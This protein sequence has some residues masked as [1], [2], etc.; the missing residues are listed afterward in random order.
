MKRFAW[1]AAIAV[2]AIVIWA[3]QLPAADPPPPAAK[4]AAP[5]SA[6]PAN[7]WPQ[8]RGPN[9]NG[10]SSETITWPAAGPKQLWKAA[11]G[12]GYSSVSVSQG[13]AYTMG[14][15]DG[16]EIVWCLDATTGTVIW[17]YDVPGPLTKGPLTNKPKKPGGFQNPYRGPNSTPTVDG[18]HV[19]TVSRDGLLSALNAVKGTL[20]WSVDYMR[21]FGAKKLRWGHAGSPLVDGDLLF[22]NVGVEGASVVAFDKTTGKV[23]W[24][25]GYDGIGFASPLSVKLGG[26]PV[27]LMFSATGLFAYNRADG[28]L[29][30]N[31][32]WAAHSDG[33]AADPII[34]G[35]KVFI[36]SAY[37]VG[38]CLLKVTDS[39]ATEVYR[40]K[41]FQSHFP[42]PVLIG[43]M[44]YG[45]TGHINSKSKLVCYDPNTGDIKWEKRKGG[46]G[47][48]AAGNTLLIQSYKGNLI[49]IEATAETYKEIGSVAALPGGVCWTPP[50]LA[51]GLVYCRNAEGDVV[52]LD[53]G[54]GGAGE[55]DV[56]QPAPDAPPKTKQSDQGGKIPPEMAQAMQQALQM[57][58]GKGRTKVLFPAALEWL[59]KDPT[60]ALAWVNE[61]PLP[62]ASFG[63]VSLYV[64]GRC[65]EHHGKITVDWLLQCK[66]Y[67]QLHYAMHFWATV[68]PSAALA[69]CLQ[70]P[71][72]VRHLVFC[73]LGDGWTYKDPAAA[74]AAFQELK[75]PTDRRSMA[76]GICKAWTWAHSEDASAATAW[77]LGLKSQEERLAALYGIGQGWVRKHLPETTAWI[78]ALQD[79]AELRAA[80]YGAVKMIQTNL[81]ERDKD[82]KY[83]AA[84]AK[85]WLE[86]FPLS[87]A[88]KTAILNGPTIG[89]KD[90]GKVPWPQ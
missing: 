41:K 21:D 32:E 66:E 89:M 59:K 14:N 24:K 56:A 58:E 38:C 46:T 83:P 60:A 10:I 11:V 68:E 25:S 26:Q 82:T 29:L 31:A 61:H 52:C 55:T 9:R 76:Y 50:S 7:D 1:C 70:A 33:N 34:F 74:T 30:W 87:D 62:K 49:A 88:E 72:E 22:V 85:E 2:A 48:I 3:V 18:N 37:R 5:D 23:V 71:D 79:K 15:V 16:Q 47:L 67:G 27:I 43:G 44:L 75:S 78:K 57:P 28:E 86:Q 69:W 77:A 42:N 65:G 80:A 40:N 8:W 84:Y 64:V 73:S 63:S 20:V 6:G 51:N 54:G 36:S 19:Y 90:T 13:R 45:I 12:V 53:L 17:Q 4:P 35:D 39:S 81:V